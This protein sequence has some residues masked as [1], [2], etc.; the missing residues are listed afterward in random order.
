LVQ[1]TEKTYYLYN[2]LE[3]EHKFQA[4]APLKIFGSGSSH[5]NCLD[6]GSTA[7]LESTLVSAINCG[8]KI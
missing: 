7:L 5:Q 1:K 6:S 4:P 2:S 3:P 8:A